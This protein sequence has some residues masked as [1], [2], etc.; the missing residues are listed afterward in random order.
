MMLGNS[1]KTAFIYVFGLPYYT[2]RISIN[3]EHDLINIR[4][5]S[6]SPPQALRPYFQEGYLVGTDDITNEYT[7][8]GELDLNSRL[9]AKFEI[10]NTKIFWGKEF[11]K[12]PDSALYPKNDTIEAICK[13]IGQE[14]ITDIAPANLGDFLKLWTEFEQIMI[15]DARTFKREVHSTRDAMMTLMKYREEEYDLLKEFDALRIFRNKLV[16]NPTGISNG[17]LV[18]MTQVLKKIRLDY[19]KNN[20]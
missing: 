16:H 6:I 8:K 19:K 7:N 3:S 15:N 2:N 13:E 17:D 4:L 12:I 14:L 10:P 20:R 5:L 11:D 9:I 18:E 1:E